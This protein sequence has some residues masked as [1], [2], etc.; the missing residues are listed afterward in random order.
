[1]TLLSGPEDYVVVDTDL[2]SYLFKNDNRAEPYL[3]FLD[4]KRLDI[5]FMTLAELYQWANI[6]NWGIKRQ[7][8]MEFAI[9]KQY[10][11]HWVNTKLCQV[12]AEV[13]CESRKLGRPI[14]S[15]D[16]WIAATAITCKVPLVTNNRKDFEHL[17]RLQL[18]T[19]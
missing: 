11:I 9:K 14:E 6:A 12:W 4:R 18:L 3:P 19:P 7:Q 13:K 15:S 17:T 16:A 2:W 10:E 1:M 8:E 5:S